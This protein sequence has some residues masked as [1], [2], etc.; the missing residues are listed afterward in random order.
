MLFFALFNKFLVGDIC[1]WW[2]SQGLKGKFVL[3]LHGWIVLHVAVY[4]ATSEIFTCI[5]FVKFIKAFKLFHNGS[6]LHIITE[7]LVE[8]VAFSCFLKLP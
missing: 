5:F 3:F 8:N 6:F 1:G 2:F 7:E 4:R